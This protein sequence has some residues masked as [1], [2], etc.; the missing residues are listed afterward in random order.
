M[1]DTELALVALSQEPEPPI[2]VTSGRPAP[3]SASAAQRGKAR[4]AWE[5]REPVG[6]RWRQLGQ[7]NCAEVCGTPLEA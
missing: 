3:P 7:A 6:G 2:S 1:K 4:Q 5:S